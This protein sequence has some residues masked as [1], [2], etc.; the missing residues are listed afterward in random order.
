M[1]KQANAPLARNFW[2]CNYNG[3]GDRDFEGNNGIGNSDKEEFIFI[4]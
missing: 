2:S 3:I 4:S 1:P